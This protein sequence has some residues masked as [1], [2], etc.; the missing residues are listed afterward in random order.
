M[1]DEDAELVALIDNELD[2][3]SRNALSARLAADERLRQRYD[4]LRAPGAPI[5]GSLEELLGR[6]DDLRN[7]GILDWGFP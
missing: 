4:E 7:L 3:S 1:A 6:G 2:E 5:A